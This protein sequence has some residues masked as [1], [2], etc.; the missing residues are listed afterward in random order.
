MYQRLF[1]TSLLCLAVVND[2]TPELLDQGFGFFVKGL[3][4]N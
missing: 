3:G 1:D 2:H 4:K